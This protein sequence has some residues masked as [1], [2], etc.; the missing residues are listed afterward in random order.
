MCY[1]TQTLI[2]WG[3]GEHPNKP[4]ASATSIMLLCPRKFGRKETSW[5]MY[6][7]TI[8]RLAAMYKK[9]GNKNFAMHCETRL[10]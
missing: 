9:L 10:Y 2:D 4:D 5:G 8:G 3:G 1:S 6:L 7:S